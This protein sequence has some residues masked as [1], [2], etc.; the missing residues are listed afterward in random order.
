M[1]F[2]DADRSAFAES[3]PVRA[4]A[5][6]DGTWR[7][8]ATG[9]GEILSSEHASVRAALTAALALEAVSGFVKN[10]NLRQDGEPDGVWRWLDATA[11]EDEPIVDKDGGQSRIGEG[12]IWGMAE[13][14][15]A[16]GSAIPING[17]GG[18]EGLKDSAPHGDAYTGGDHPAN[19]FAHV[20]LVAI[21][22]TGRAH[23]F[24]YSEL[25]PEIAAEVDRGRLAYGSVRFWFDGVDESD[26]FAVTNAGLISHALTNDPAVTTLTAGS[27]RYREPGQVQLRRAV[28]SRWF[29][30]QERTTMTTI[31]QIRALHATATASTGTAAERYRAARELATQTRGAVGD[32]LKDVAAIF[33]L[34]L[35]EIRAD[36]WKLPDA[37]FAMLD[38]LKLEE[39]LAVANGAPK[40][41]AEP[42]A[43]EV[44]AEAR[45]SLRGMAKRG[46]V[47]GAVL[48]QRAVEDMEGEALDAFA[49]D[50]LAFGRKVLGK[51]E[52]PAADV[53][54]ELQAVEEKVLAALA[55]EDAEEPADPPA[56]DPKPKE[57][58]AA[59]ADLRAAYRAR[60][61]ERA[62]AKALGAKVAYFE[63]RD[64]L[65]AELAKRSAKIGK[66][67]TLPKDKR[68]RW[69]QMSLKAGREVVLELIDGLSA[70]PQGNP[71][72]D[73]ETPANAK[74]PAS[75]IEAF[76]AC[77]EDAR[78]HVLKT[79]PDDASREHVVRAAAQKI[80]RERWPDIFGTT[81]H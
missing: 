26:N 34:T 22:A 6:A 33:G 3:V 13:S 8:V 78:T 20:G 9:S 64:W 62:K 12:A 65:D 70:P 35:E 49:A 11:V 42:P 44:S 74:D 71:M 80:A 32:L 17:G 43:G 79:S 67:L 21:D 46:Y 23:L 69:T 48:S 53:L 16:R 39:A 52:A 29:P 81:T 15:N 2:T 59:S 47:L 36:H 68:E 14:L 37:V 4:E 7:L 5:A 1:P 24:I 40:P 75:Q 58:E 19:G 31:D 60:N 18:P 41:A 25:L 28:R 45:E 54:A 38:A 61:A 57:G 66:P 73:T 51:P 10:A 72:L 56:D 77:M 30:D 63:A 27:E 50:V 76:D 55:D